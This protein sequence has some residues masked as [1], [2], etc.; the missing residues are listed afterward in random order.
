MEMA[1]FGADYIYIFG[2]GSSPGM[3]QLGWSSVS[4][5]DVLSVLCVMPGVHMSS[6]LVEVRES[7]LEHCR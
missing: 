1:N 5:R 3:F 7:W 2:I 4:Q 6:R